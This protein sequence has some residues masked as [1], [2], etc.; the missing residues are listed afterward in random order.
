MN[1][2]FNFQIALN[3][4]AQDIFRSQADQD[5]IS[6][7][8]SYFMGFQQQFLWSAQ[9]AVE[10]YLKAI[11]LYNGNTARWKKEPNSNGNGGKTFGHDLIALNSKVKEIGY[12]EYSLPEWGELYLNKLAKFGGANRYLSQWSDTTYEDLEKLDE[13]VWYIRRYCFFIRENTEK[14]SFRDTKINSIKSKSFPTMHN[15]NDGLLEKVIKNKSTARDA[16]VRENRVYGTENDLLQETQISSS[17]IP[18]RDRDWF[19]EDMKE[20]LEYFIQP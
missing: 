7:R 11:L 6:A 3:A 15:L 18:P 16:L 12:L 4:C 2:E 17:I 1:D 8:S 13:L 9:Q 14:M 20:R 19:T 5:Y 10:K